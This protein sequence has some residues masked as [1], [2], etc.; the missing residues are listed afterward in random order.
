MVPEMT[1]DS[2]TNSPQKLR[3]LIVIG[4][5]G[6]AANIVNVAYSLQYSIKAFVNNGRFGQT[7]FDKPVIAD[8]NQIDSL[9]EYDFCLA[10]GDNYE[11]EK[12]LRDALYRYPN[13]SFPAL[14]HPTVSIGPFSKVGE[15][16]IVM[17]NSVI[18]TNAAVGSFCF[19]GNQSCVGH[20][21]ALS[22]FSSLGPAATLAGYVTLGRRSVVGIGAKV[23]ERVSIGDDV[24]LGANSFLNN[25]LPEKVIALGTP[26]KIK[27]TRERGD[28]YLR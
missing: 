19:L 4:S 13:L 2:L 25:D 28:R 8:I 10:L 24:V 15:G 17:P 26:A 3:Q 5:G 27:K 18:G 6:Q 1:N 20:D 7:L 16:S 23:R 9:T 12:Y 14:I 11:R 21:S 22:D